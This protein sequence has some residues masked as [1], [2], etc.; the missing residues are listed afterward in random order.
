LTAIDI[1]IIIQACTVYRWALQCSVED[2]WLNTVGKR[3][4]NNYNPKVNN[5]STRV[6]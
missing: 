6:D 2:F 1:I 3:L 4:N 5:S